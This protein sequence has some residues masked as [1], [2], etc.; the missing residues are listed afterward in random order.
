MAQLKSPGVYKAKIKDYGFTEP[1]AG[2]NPQAMVQFTIIEEGPL[3]KDPPDEITWYAS[4]NGGALPITLETLVHTLGFRGQ[5]GAELVE[6]I[7]SKMLNEDAVYELDCQNE[8]WEGKER[9]KVKWINLEGAARR[10]EKLDAAGAKIFVGG[11]NLAGELASM[12]SKPGM[13]TPP[14]LNTKEKLPF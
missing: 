10:M 5:T 14:T 11:M 2:K 12:R 6:G 7:G 1:K 3:P 4:F 13:N 8:T 9:L